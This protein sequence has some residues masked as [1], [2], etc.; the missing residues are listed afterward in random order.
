MEGAGPCW[1][2]EPRSDKGVMKN[3]G[4]CGLRKRGGKTMDSKEEGQR[5][6]QLS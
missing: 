2:E 1:E 6:P 3:I 5:K 4:Q